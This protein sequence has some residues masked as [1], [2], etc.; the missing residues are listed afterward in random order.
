MP[1]PLAPSGNA[2]PDMG[3][4][5]HA[6]NTIKIVGDAQVYGVLWPSSAPADSWLISPDVTPMRLAAE[7]VRP[8]DWAQNPY[9]WALIDAMGNGAP[10]PDEAARIV[11][12]PVNEPLAVALRR[13]LSD[14]VRA[15]PIIATGDAATY[16][17]AVR[18]VFMAAG[19]LLDVVAVDSDPL[20]DDADQIAE[21]LE[22]IAAVM[23]RKRRGEVINAGNRALTRSG[24]WISAKRLNPWR[25]KQ[26]RDDGHVTRLSDL[27]MARLQTRH[28]RSIVAQRVGWTL[29]DVAERLRPGTGGPPDP[30]APPLPD[31]S[32]TPD[33]TP[34]PTPVRPTL[35]PRGRPSTR[36]ENPE[37]TP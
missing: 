7:L 17:D 34:T 37:G 36:P 21:M 24:R 33:P 13:M 26:G 15:A 18:A 32:P 29:A 19:D 22:A 27:L 10:K 14:Y 16:A 25:R 6:T 35:R 30:S 11:S 31:P 3:A 8:D 23:R 28:G 9:G 12:R 4:L 20:P 2:A 5:T 1:D